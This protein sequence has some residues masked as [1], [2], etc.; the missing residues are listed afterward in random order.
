MGLSSQA[1]CELINQREIVFGKALLSVLFI[2]YI[3]PFEDGNKR[4]G[5]IM[6]N[7]ILIDNKY[8]PLSYRSIKPLDY[9]KAM[10]LFYE[11]NNVALYKKLF[12]DQFEFAVNNYF[13]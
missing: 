2:S 1:A 10:I 7:G 4:T 3:Q 11:Q 12:M 5:R 13:R 9:K 6:G 8:C